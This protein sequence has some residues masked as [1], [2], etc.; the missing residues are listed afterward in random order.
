[1]R[2]IQCQ[3]GSPE[4]LK[5]RLGLPT[6]SEFDQIITSGKLTP[7]A[8][9]ARYRARLVAEKFL[10]HQLD[11]G[12]SG[13]MDR[14]T[15]L[16]T[17]AAAWFELETGLNAD[18]VGL[19]VTDAGDIGASPDRMIGTDG[20][21][22]IKCPSALT[23]TQYL[24]SGFDDYRLQVQGQLWVTGR[25]FA[26]QLSYHPT[27]PPVLIRVERDPKVMKAFDK[28]LPAFVASLALA[29]AKLYAMIS[30]G[31]TPQTHIQDATHPF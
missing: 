11:E 19:C 26:Y 10:G 22:E 1:M 25:E 30:Q 28:H 12:G 2:I 20:V 27:I 8:S 6:A 13:F 5:A 9:Q 21:L 24:L 16:E 29:R 18:P 4:W 3:Q 17:E 7:S 15:Q 14:G 31:S 23:H